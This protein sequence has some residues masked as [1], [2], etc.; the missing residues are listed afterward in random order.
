MNKLE[1]A[2]INKLDICNKTLFNRLVYLI[3]YQYCKN[4]DKL[5]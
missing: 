1:I 3:E 2:A 4:T 5:T